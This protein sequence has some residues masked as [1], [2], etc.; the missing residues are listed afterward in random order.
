MFQELYHYILHLA[1]QLG[2]IGIII[3]MA[4]ESS[5]I[6]LPS[7]IV[8]IPAGILVFQGK[9]NFF[10]AS[11]CGA[12][13]SY[14]GSVLNYIGAYYLGRPF[15]IKYGKYFFL[16]QHKFEKVENFFNKYGSISIF[17]ARLLPVVRHFISI[18]AGCAKMNFYKFSFY[19]LFG[20]FVW[21][22]V[23]TYIG[24]EIG[25]NIE[26]LHKVMPVVKYGT[27]ALCVA[28]ILYIIYRAKR[29]NG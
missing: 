18:P 21:M 6:P 20:S 5:L 22:V 4:I 16:P 14:I 29:K 8:M 24:Y 17:I 2:Y 11:I 26:M 23:L 7:E 9:M 3:G 15:V 27:I 12:V 1:Y 13:G 25:Q 28:I 19:T 10:V